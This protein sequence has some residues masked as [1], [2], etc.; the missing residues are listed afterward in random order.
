MAL[1]IIWTPK[2]DEGLEKVLEYLEEEWT[3]HEILNLEKKLKNLLEHI[4]K[5]PESCPPTNFRKNL[6]KGL[7]DKNNYIVF[8]VNNKKKIIEIINFRGT[9]QK[10]IY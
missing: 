9:K 3:S 10:S 6:Y 7:I 4:I 5:Y 8:R 2:A 1:K